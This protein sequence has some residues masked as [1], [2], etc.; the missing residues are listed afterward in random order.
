MR[1]T[2]GGKDIRT[3]GKTMF[4][5][6]VESKFQHKMGKKCLMSKK[7]HQKIWRKWGKKAWVDGKNFKSYI[8]N[9]KMFLTIPNA[10]MDHLY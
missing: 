9:K 6:E 2:L 10:K 3:K 8:Q 5:G 7:G 4:R 1:E